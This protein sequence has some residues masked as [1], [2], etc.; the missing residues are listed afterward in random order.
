MA[1]PRAPGSLGT[2]DA[3]LQHS[4]AHPA[5]S[6]AAGVKCKT[7]VTSAGGGREGVGWTEEIGS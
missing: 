4:G 7:L 3:R 1:V 2:A 6:Q 5:F